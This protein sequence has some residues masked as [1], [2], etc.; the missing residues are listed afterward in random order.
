[1]PTLIGRNLLALMST[2]PRSIA[3][4]E[5]LGAAGALLFAGGVTCA[6]GLLRS[7]EAAQ[8]APRPNTSPA[9]AKAGSRFFL[10][11]GGGAARLGVVVVGG[12]TEGGGNGGGELDIAGEE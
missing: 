7:E 3:S 6:V 1:M 4:A 9:T 12:A 8:A 11:G 10:G 2:S 5:P